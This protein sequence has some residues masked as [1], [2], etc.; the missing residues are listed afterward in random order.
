VTSS[1]DELQRLR[2][3][4]CEQLREITAR[5]AAFDQD[6]RTFWRGGSLRRVAAIEHVGW[7]GPWAVE[8]LQQSL[9]ESELNIRLAAVEALG[10]IPGRAAEEALRDA[11]QMTPDP[12]RHRAITL[13]RGRCGLRDLDFLVSAL[14]DPREE[15]RAVAAEG[16]GDLGNARAV[17]ALTAALRTASIGGSARRQQWL[18]WAMAAGGVVLY[19]VAFWGIGAHRL[20]TMMLLLSGFSFIL[21]Q[22]SEGRRKRN[23]P[24]LAIIQALQKLADRAPS[25]ELRDAL[26]ELRV[27]AGDRLQVEPEA[28][29]AARELAGRIEDLTGRSKDLPLP[30]ACRGADPAALPRAGQSPAA[31]PADLRVPVQDSRC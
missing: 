4:R 27:M 8:P 29:R 20:G 26:G 6:M 16:L 5:R 14:A 21:A 9:R 2:A 25:P 30:S 19:A 17:G 15:V 24:R 7:L 13:L 12:V 10:K 3:I 23:A 18:G 28:R 1:T 11:A 22:V 31:E